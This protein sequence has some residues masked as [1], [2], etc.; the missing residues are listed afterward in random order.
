MPDPVNRERPMEL[1]TGDLLGALS[2]D[3]IMTNAAVTIQVYVLLK[4]IIAEALN[5]YV[6]LLG[7]SEK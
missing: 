5:G 1:P 7:L 6:S 2:C 4:L 3:I